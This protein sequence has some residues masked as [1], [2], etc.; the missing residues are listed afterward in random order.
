MYI[1]TGIHFMNTE[2]FKTVIFDIQCYGGRIWSKFTKFYVIERHFSTICNLMYTRSLTQIPKLKSK[3]ALF[4]SLAWDKWYD[5]EICM[6]FEAFLLK[7]NTF[8][9]LTT[10]KKWLINP[11][12]N[13]RKI[14]LK[15]KTISLKMKQRNSLAEINVCECVRLLFISLD[16]TCIARNIVKA[17]CFRMGSQRRERIQ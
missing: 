14:E 11:K 9:V 2:H 13:G 10:Y 15:T 4:S 8:A 5:Y 1:A 3:S 7:Q 6:Q 17:N 12:W 16:C